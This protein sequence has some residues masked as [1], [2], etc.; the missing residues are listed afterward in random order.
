MQKLG[1]N[2][3]YEQSSG[4]I[5]AK[6][7]LAVAYAGYYDVHNHCHVCVTDSIYEKKTAGVDTV[8]NCSRRKANSPL[9]D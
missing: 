8:S 5:V 7:V 4:I 9:K 2:T 6:N 3:D 1:D